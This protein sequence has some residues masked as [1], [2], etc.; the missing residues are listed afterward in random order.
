[1]KIVLLLYSKIYLVLTGIYELFVPSDDFN[2]YFRIQ[3]TIRRSLAQYGYVFSK[4]INQ[5][6]VWR[7]R[8]RIFWHFHWKLSSWNYMTIESFSPLVKFLKEKTKNFIFQIFETNYIRTVKAQNLDGNSFRTLQWFWIF[9]ILLFFFKQE[10][11]KERSWV[12]GCNRTKHCQVQFNKYLANTSV[13][14]QNVA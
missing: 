3:N 7:S 4:Q 8:Q 13:L 5:Y 11:C 10:T 6:N 14:R 2:F 9:N 1:M 12:R